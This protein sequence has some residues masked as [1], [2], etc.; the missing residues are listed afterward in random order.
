MAPEHK[1]MVS[2]LVVIELMVMQEAC[3]GREAGVF[4]IMGFQEVEW[5]A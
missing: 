3:V 5:Y 2:R 1:T 4:G